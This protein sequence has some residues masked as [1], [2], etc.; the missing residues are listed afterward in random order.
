MTRYLTVEQIYRL[1]AVGE[2][3]DPG[4]DHVHLLRNEGTSE[5]RTVAVQ[6][7]PSGATRRIDAEAPSG[8]TV[9]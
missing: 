7:L 3:I 4:G 9:R 1:H 6:L 5:A 8:C 2:P